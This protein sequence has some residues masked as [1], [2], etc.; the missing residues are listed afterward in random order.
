MDTTAT[1][2]LELVAGLH[3]VMQFLAVIA[4]GLL[5]LDL[6]DAI[7]ADLAVQRWVPSRRGGSGK[8]SQK[9]LVKVDRFGVP[10]P[11]CSARSSSSPP[12]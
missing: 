7:R 3:P 2:I 12:S 6:A 10:M 4:G 8:R 1:H 9:V 5:A 11:A